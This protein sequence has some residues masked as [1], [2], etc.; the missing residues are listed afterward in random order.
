MKKFLAF[1]CAAILALGVHLRQ[2]YLS[3]DIHILR[4]TPLAISHQYVWNTPFDEIFI[5]A[6]NGDE[7][8]GVLF[9][10]P[11]PAKGVI[12]YLHGRGNNLGDFWGF[13]I[14]DYVNYGYDVFSIDYR[15]FGKSKGI[16][17]ENTL[18]E[19]SDLAYN[20]LL[21]RYSEKD[22]VVY[23]QSL[24]TGFATYV[25]SKHNPKALV[26]E[27]PYYNMIE[28]AKN[29]KP[30]LPNFVLKLMLKYHLRT[31][32]WIKEVSCP[33]HIFHGTKDR[34]IPYSSGQKLYQLVEDK[35]TFY[36]LEGWGH[37]GMMCHKD[38][39]LSMQQ[40]LETSRNTYPVL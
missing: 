27:A 40:I 31:D 37:D 30:Y 32:L 35:A 1:F 36:T 14:Q 28:M 7:V 17:T 13:R 5:K 16:I 25:A 26:L 11:S 29:A 12:L 22:I 38:Y 18:L 20:F 33:I 10:S 34:I 4:S 23:G 19:D 6:P 39:I 21:E 2:T 3:Q 8:N 9:H 15:G 24:G